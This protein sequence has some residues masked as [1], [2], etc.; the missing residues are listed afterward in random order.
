MKRGEGW[1]IEGPPEEAYERVTEPER[2]APLHEFGVALADRLE[3]TFD[4][5]RVE[6]YGL[7]PEI[8][9]SDTAR[10]SIRLTPRDDGAA[11]VTVS[12][13][14]FPGLS[15]RLGRW[16]TEPFPSCGCDACDETAEGE[17][18]RFE[19]FVEAVTAGWF[20][21]AIEVSPDGTAWKATSFW[22][23]GGWRSM[24]HARLEG[25]RARRMIAEGGGRDFQ[26]KPWGYR[27]PPA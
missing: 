18:E 15:V 4:V 16:Y 8:G 19:E 11:P 7:D 1:G 9:R 2:F 17:I 14:T 10:P 5:E 21:E 22:I 6:G 12:F 25:S 13:S 20:R 3:A 27:R 24:D 26:W 23:P